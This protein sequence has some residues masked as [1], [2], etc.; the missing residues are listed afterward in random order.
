VAR[1]QILAI[2]ALRIARAIPAAGV[3][4][5][6]AMADPVLASTPQ[7]NGPGPF[8]GVWLPWLVL[9]LVI[10][11]GIIAWAVVEPFATPRDGYRPEE[12]LRVS[13][14]ALAIFGVAIASFGRHTRSIA[15]NGAIITASMLM[16]P[17]VTLVVGLQLLNAFVVGHRVLAR[18]DRSGA[19]I[20][21]PHFTVATLT[22]ISLWIGLISVTAA[23]KVHYATVYAAVLILPLLYWW[24]TAAA[25][26]GRVGRVL[27]QRGPVMSGSERAWTALLMTMV[28]LHLFVVAKPETGYDAVAM[29]LQIP[30]LMA[31]MH[32]WPFDVT[33]YAWAVMPMG[34]DWAFTAAYFVGGEG[35]ARLL[36]FCFAG[37]ACLLLF[38]LVRRY[39]RRDIALASAC[40]VASTPLAFL[41]TGTLYVENLWTAFLL[42]SLLLA[43]DYLRSAAKDLLLALAFLAAGAMQC[44]VIGV[45]WLAPLLLTVGFLVWRRH[46]YRGFSAREIALLGI[47]VAIA[48]W[49]YA[50]AWLRTGN[51]VFPFMNAL[52]RSPL[53]DTGTSFNNWL[54]NAPLRPW[55]PYEMIWSSGRFIEGADGAAGFQWLLLF[56]VIALAFLRRRPLAQWLCLA[57]AAIVF[58]GV[59]SQQ[60]Y[61]RYLLPV[62][63]LVAV[64]GGWA[65]D[66]IPDSRA[67]RVAILLVGGILCA[68]N[69]RLMYTAGW[70]NAVLC[71]SCATDSR[72]RREYV[73]QYKPDRIAADYLN[74]YLPN[75][76]VGFYMI[77]APSPAGYVGYSRAANWHDYPSFRALTMAQTAEDVLAHAKKFGLTHIVYRDPPWE[78]ENAA[79]HAFREKYTVPVWRANGIVVAAIELPPGP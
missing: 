79:M 9:L 50:N 55:S 14:I 75:A 8:P 28:V 51:P 37:L 56:P 77:G 40:L 22:G 20:H 34:A 2:G 10:H 23:L 68:I 48:A 66:E 70:A 39:A 41:E 33:R 35:A 13:L 65:L 4:I 52:F 46:G 31:E 59:F 7:P 1:C 42:G 72:A 43:L 16:T 26:L 15:W 18:V 44:K 58:V 54:Y 3:I 24:R 12:F 62:F 19:I 78:S 25:A 11:A 21:A 47:A 27:V 36:N 6:G 45:I 29:H 53:F 61:L 74:A 60:S 73:A 69:V 49:P 32:R 71:P 67:T 30:L 76:R 63:A 17:A 5:R 64:L 38:E 57:L